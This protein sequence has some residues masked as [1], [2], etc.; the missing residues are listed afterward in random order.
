MMTNPYELPDLPYDYSELKPSISPQLLE[1]HHSKHHAAYVKGANE[2]LEKLAATRDADDYSTVSRLQKLLAFNL[3]GHVLHSLFW[4]CMSPSGGEP[5]TGRLQRAIDAGFGSYDRLKQQMNASIAQL[6]GSGWAALAWEPVA[7]TLI[8]EQVYDHQSNVGQGTDLVLVID[9]WEHAYY[10]D[11]LNDKA[12]WTDAF[13]EV[14]DWQSAAT[15][16]DVVSP[17][18]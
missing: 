2:A 10:L 16:F 11:Y 7:E 13:W 17:A 5:P 18:S 1:L 9:G 6:Q 8:I 4:T 12:A 15:R 3:S 14:V